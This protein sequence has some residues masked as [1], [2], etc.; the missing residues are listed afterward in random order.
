M[1]D[2]RGF[3]GVMAGALGAGPLRAAEGENPLP[4][5]HPET[6]P[7]NPL[8]RLPKVPRVVDLSSMGREAGRQGGKISAIIGG[9]RDIRLMT[10]NGYSRLVTYDPNLQLHADILESFTVDEDRIFTFRLREGHR[11]SDGTPVSTEDFRYGW[12]DYVMDPDLRPGGLPSELLSADK[13]PVFEILDPLTVRYTWETPNPSFLPRLAAPQ[14]LTI[15]LP[16]HYMRQFHAKYQDAELL[17]ALVAHHEVDDW[18]DLHA[19]MSRSYRPE[20]PDLPTLDPWRN[21]T[22]P[23][24][25]QFVFVRNPYFHRVDENGVQ[26]PYI[27][28]V[29]LNVAQSGII[30]AKT[31]AGES[32]LQM[33]SIDFVDYPY[34]KAAEKNH[35]VKLV[36]WRRTQG[37]RLALVPN[38]NCTDPVW[39][40]LMQDPRVRRALSLGVNR[41]E[42]NAA[43]FFGLATPSADTVLPASPLYR[44][45]YAAAWSAYDPDTANALLDEVGLT[46]RRYDGLRLLPDGRPMWIIV[47]SAGESTLEADVM[48]LVAD[49]WR[50]I[51]VAPFSRVSQRD[52]MRSRALAGEIV[53]SIWQGID[54]GV[55]TA[56]MSPAQLAPTADDQLAWPLWGMHWFTRETK[57]E[58]PD[59]P[60]AVELLDLYK[61]WLVS[62][63]PA[64]REEIWHKMLSIRADQVFTIGIVNETLQPIMHNS[65][66]RNFP[67]EGLYGFDPTCYLGVYMP[68]TFWLDDGE[69]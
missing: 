42:I 27:D 13:G 7:E 51:G 59:L 68:D 31:G 34:L 41:E 20:N 2:R 46:E 57:G 8:D 16:A 21:T 52:I 9:Q 60:V 32:D 30:S 67:P 29:V 10:V 5:T 49:H 36:T 12:E 61:R 35:P 50:E 53:M 19:R 1:I 44:P 22:P 48:E 39:R 4:P 55:A 45:E 28:R 43:L 63:S 64:E 33:S 40:S 65:R 14:P 66:M 15:M 56:D 26:L 11:W 3:L 18:T 38:L 37:S 62:G 24:A 54:N 23:P 47:E 17:D 6:V 25:D 58:P 69:A